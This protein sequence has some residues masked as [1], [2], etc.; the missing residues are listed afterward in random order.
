M[1]RVKLIQVVPL[2]ASSRWGRGA[3][4]GDHPRD[5]ISVLNI[6]VA[7]LERGAGTAGLGNRR[8]RELELIGFLCILACLKLVDGGNEDRG[9]A[10]S[11]GH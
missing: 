5:Y 6:D 11:K 3:M 4:A 10:L 1:G 9:S 2:A 8:G 7:D